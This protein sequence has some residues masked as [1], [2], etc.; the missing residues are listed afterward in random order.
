MNILG[1]LI[2]IDGTTNYA[3]RLPLFST[4]IGILFENY[5]LGGLI[6]I[7]VLNNIYKATPDSA[8]K[9]NKKI[10]VSKINKL[11][12]ALVVTGFPYLINGKIDLMLDIIKKITTKTR[13]MRRTGSAAIDL[14]WVSEGIFT[15]HFEMGLKPWDTAA[16]VAILE[17]AGGKVTDF[18]NRPYNLQSSDI[19]ASNGILH[20]EIIE[21]LSSSV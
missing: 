5:P 2:P 4:S 11:E 12:Q 9:D 16:G 6:S 15:V 19:L 18:K 21:I 13:G 3:Y 1:S 14:A 7:P 8:T 17:A 20:E 10:R